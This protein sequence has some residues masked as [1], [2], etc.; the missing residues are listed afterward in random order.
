MRKTA[1]V[2]FIAAVVLAGTLGAF[3]GSGAD[4]LNAETLAELELRSI[5]PNLVTGRVAD[6]EVDPSRPNVYYVAA[7]AGGLWKSENRGNTWTPIFDT[8]GSFNLC[9]ILIDPKNSNNLYLATGENSN[10]RSAM[11]GDGIYKSTDAGATWKRVG[12]ETSEHIGNMQMDPRNSNVIYVAAMGPLWSSGGDRGI[13]KTTDGG[14]NWKAVLTV[15]ADT[16]G[17]EVH[18][19]PNNPDVLYAST[20]QRRRG[21]GQM[22]GGGRESAIYKSTNAGATWTKLTTGLP[23]GD[24]GRIAMGVD[25]KAKPTRV[26][27]LINALVDTGFYRSDDAGA[28]WTRQGAPLGATAPPAPAADPAQP[29]ARGGGGGGRG[30]GIPG[31]YR[32]GDPGY[33]YELYVDPVRPDTIWSANTNLDWSRDGGKTFSP[34]PNMAGVHVDYHDVWLDK[35]DK[36][37]IVASSDGGVYESWDEGRTWRHFTNLPIS[38]FYR[39]SVDNAKP[40][41]H[42]CGGTQDNGSMCGPSRT[43]NNVGIRTSDWYS[44]GGGDGFQTRND[45]DDPNI[46][47][48]TSQNGAVQRLDLRTGRS[49]SIRPGGRGGGGET[50]AGF[51]AGDQDPPVQSP[52]APARGGGAGA[53]GGGRGG[54]RGGGERTNWDATYIISPHSST[55]LYWGSH[56]LYRSE[57]RGDSWTTISEDLTRNLDPRVIPIM[58]RVW[59]PVETVAYNNA[60]T[61]LSTIVTLDESPLFE[62]LLYVGTD[63]GNLNVTEDG[64]KTWRKT[65]QFASIPDGYYVTDVFAS[66]RDANVVFIT[67]NNWQRGDFTP[68]VLRSDDRGRTFRSIAGNLPARQPAWSIIQDHVNGNL[69]FLGTEFGL[70]VTVDGGTRWTQLKGGLP[71]AQV[72]DMTVQRRETDL[73]LGTF[74]RG[75]YILDDYSPLREITPQALTQEAELFPLRHAY[76]FDTLGQQ[77][78]AWGNARTPNPPYGAHLTYHVAPGFTGSL[79]LDISNAAGQRVR[80]LQIPS[81]AGLHRVTW[82][83]T[84]E[85]SA[86]PAAGGRGGDLEP[87]VLEPSE[88]QTGGAAGG[89]QG[90]ARAGGAQGGG[91]GGAGAQGRGAGRGGGGGGRG[92]G[93]GGER[94]AP[95]RYSATLAKVSGD[96]TT[97]IG[98]TQTFQVVPLPARNY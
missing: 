17:N 33:Y 71:T 80:R 77:R 72:R 20:W 39:V 66:P 49:Q 1:F 84:G 89:A 93:G 30:G 15:S 58:G 21:V 9:C 35:Q 54:G 50:E 69:L 79:V 7:A 8:G 25:P 37:H 86:A 41:Y 16:G 64:G 60:T 82:D 70:F 43:A 44:V 87:I 67:L 23:K 53:Q 3:Q 88:Q 57:D 18:I 24:M 5:G 55:R 40:F 68:Y 51:D 38:Q 52:P 85:P 6:F 12:L 22:I 2:F 31:V 92:G 75:F 98:K 83:L 76:Q 13:Y 28:T 4:R 81:T 29:P 36:N 78:A 96:Q 14:A 90:G 91:A 74:G 63:D 10:P 94:V 62:G 19:D 32:G 65:T 45:P 46:V 48:A 61:T 97:P 47:Y 95:G 27:A 56:R 59:D 73:V 34:V 26:Y 11:M 42:V